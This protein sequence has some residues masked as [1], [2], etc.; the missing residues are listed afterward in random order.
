MD[1]HF[2]TEGVT[3][4]CWTGRHKKK[5][6]CNEDRVK[7]KISS[8]CRMIISNVICMP[9]LFG[10]L[11]SCIISN[12]RTKNGFLHKEILV[13]LVCNLWTFDQI[14]TPSPFTRRVGFFLSFFFRS[15]K[16]S[17]FFLSN[18]LNYKALWNRCMV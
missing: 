11:H 4:N 5:K 8:N 3:C 2:E 9:N 18:A 1:S 12:G 17:E 15:N 6:K 13:S 14:I 7:K 10:L 16:N